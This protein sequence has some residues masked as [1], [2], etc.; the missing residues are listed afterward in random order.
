M[1][2]DGRGY[3]D[4]SGCIGSFE[5]KLRALGCQPPAFGK[6]FE[7]GVKA[8]AGG[9]FAL[10]TITA[11]NGFPVEVQA[12][13][14]G[15]GFGISLAGEGSGEAQ[16]GRFAGG[17]ANNDGLV[18]GGGEYFASVPDISGAVGGAGDGGAQIEFAAVILKRLVAGEAKVQIAERLVRGHAA[19]RGDERFAGE[20]LGFPK[21]SRGE[22]AAD[23]R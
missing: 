4:E 22:E 13:R 7:N 20:I 8:D 15:G 2:E 21:F 6:D 23:F 14:G 18:G 9:P 3:E 12:V 5:L 17:E 19:R 16:A 10:E 11:G 1:A